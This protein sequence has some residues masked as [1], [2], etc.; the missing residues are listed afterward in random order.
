MPTPFYLR[1][2]AVG[3][4]I[5]LAGCVVYQEPAPVHESQPVHIPP[6]H[7]PPPGQCRIWYPDRLYHAVR[8]DVKVP[9]KGS[10]H[11]FDFYLGVDNL[12]DSKPPLGLLG[13]AG[14]DPFDAVGRYFYAG[15]AIDL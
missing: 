10:S 4:L 3:A 2:A 13:T 15:A 14:G 7:L 8:L 5:A 11:K 9:T 12:F 6:G 1:A